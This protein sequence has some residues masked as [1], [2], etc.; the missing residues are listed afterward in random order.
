MLA[1]KAKRQALSVKRLGRF[2]AFGN[3]LQMLLYRRKTILT[4]TFQQQASFTF[5]HIK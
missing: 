1:L 4:R 5:F 2:F 3:F